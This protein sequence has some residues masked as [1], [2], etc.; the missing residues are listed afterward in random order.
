MQRRHEHSPRPSPS[1]PQMQCPRHLRRCHSSSTAA[2]T[3]G[4]PLHACRQICRLQ[5]APRAQR[6]QHLTHLQGVQEPNDTHRCYLQPADKAQQ[7]KARCQPAV[8]VLIASCR[9]CVCQACSWQNELLQPYRHLADMSSSS[10]ERMHRLP[11]S[12]HWPQSN[13]QGA[14]QKLKGI[15][16]T[17]LSKR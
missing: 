16:E 1:G 8:E 7:T 13:Q 3:P 12:M 17:I 5:Q 11:F 10:H 2:G 14:A 9:A 6:F 15:Q 4:Y